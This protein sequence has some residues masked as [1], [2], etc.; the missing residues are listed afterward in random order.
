MSP[1]EPQP[2]PSL[3]V[4]LADLPKPLD[5]KALFGREAPVEI[6]VGIG[7]GYFLSRY[8]SEHPELNLIG[9]DKVGSEIHRSHDKCRRM[10]ASNVRIVKCDALYFLEDF[11]PPASVQ[12]IHVYYSD[13]W[14]KKRHHKRRV[15]RPEFIRAAVR[16]LEP[17]GRL[18]MKT[19][20]ADYFVVIDRLLRAEP[21]LALV[22]DRRLD[23]EPL[24]G[25]YVTN[26]QRKAVAQGHPLHYQVWEKRPESSDLP[27]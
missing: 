19:D 14:P 9:L 23:H 2:V 13:P 6:E 27:R 11:P 26:F 16:C 21:A 22:E 24:E 5:Y 18:L 4:S 1:P 10:G 3:L 7:S 20:V 17:R 12:T 25:D 15:W 8:G